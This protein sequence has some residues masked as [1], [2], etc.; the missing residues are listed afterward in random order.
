MPVPQRVSALGAAC[1]W[2]PT[3][4][5]TA[6]K[7][8]GGFID[9]P[10]DYLTL[11][12]WVYQQG[13]MGFD[14]LRVW[15][16]TLEL[17]EKR[18][19]T[20]P[21]APAHYGPEELRRL[22]RAPRLAPVQEAVQRLEDLGLLAWSPQGIQFLPQAQALREALTQDS[23]QTLRAQLPPG[24][25][26][27]PVPRRL[28]VW[29]AQE[30]Q[31]G[32]IAT[33]CGVLLRCMRYKARQCVAGGRVA[34][35]WIATVFG[36]A[37][38][39]VQRAL[40]VLQG[41]G[42]LARLA[43]PP[44]RERLHGRYTVINLAWERPGAT[45]EIRDTRAAAATTSPEEPAMASCHTLSPLRGSACRNLSPMATQSMSIT[46]EN[47]DGCDDAMVAR[48]QPFQEE[49]HDPEPTG[50]GPTGAATREEHEEKDSRTPPAAP[51]DDEPVT[52]DDY[53]AATA[54]LLSQGLD[55]AL[56]I[57][58]V[59]LAEVQRVRDEVARGPA[60]A[61]GQAIEVPAATPMMT[62]PAVQ[63]AAPGACPPAPRPSQTRTAP[64]VPACAR[65][66]T[67]TPPPTLREVTLADLGDVGRLLALHQQARAR[68]WL[69]GDEAEQ[70]NVVAAAVHARRVGQAPC[71]LFV[72][73]LRDRRWEVITQED[74]DQA[75]TL[76]REH[77]N[78]PC[79]RGPVRPAATVP[80][81]PLSDDARL[82][83]LAPQVLRQ[84]GWR[85]EPFLGVKL[86]DPTW[87]RTRWEQAQA[88]LTQW[89]LRQAQARREGRNPE[90]VAETD[91]DPE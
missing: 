84:A 21:E 49:R 22:L 51:P 81:I 69:R 30:G 41:C 86:Q 37:E 16:G 31:P 6:H 13:A 20:A 75:R 64:V 88:E 85:G 43:G 63:P 54:R 9:C 27:V 82:V 19:C 33:A 91:D 12:W 89:R 78:G 34:A 36:V 1:A 50:R 28:L 60:V 35:P 3:G 59:V 83:L 5:Q 14:T 25:R 67:R 18:C 58:P 4:T 77:A 26:W 11:P 48:F 65:P 40:Q 87:T 70:L 2:P 42:W 62:A 23:Y 47:S 10:V 90:D 8:A 72:A 80:A 52:D 7:P 66:P 15:L 74:E 45:G 79:R 76:L 38:R 71:R 29:L 61:P 53:A 17:V 57:R 68:G 73:L 39:T 24:L 44:A 32:L 56:L 46:H 55:P